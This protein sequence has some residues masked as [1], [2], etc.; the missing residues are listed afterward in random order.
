MMENKYKIV[1]SEL[2]VKAV[3]AVQESV[4]DDLQQPDP[5]DKSIAHTLEESQNDKDS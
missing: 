2:V 4:A 3:G 5:T 1:Q